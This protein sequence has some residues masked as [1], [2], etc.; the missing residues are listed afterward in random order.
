MSALGA[1]ASSSWDS[2][3]QVQVSGNS[4]ACG[5]SPLKPSGELEPSHLVPFNPDLAGK[6]ESGPQEARQKHGLPFPLEQSVL[7]GTP[8][9]GR[10]D[11]A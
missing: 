1:P 6:E 8:F 5:A 2:K 3:G 4:R 11:K 10:K 7:V 9:N